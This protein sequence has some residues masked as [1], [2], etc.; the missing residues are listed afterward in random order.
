MPDGFQFAIIDYSGKVRYHSQ[1]LRNLNENLKKEFAD[2]SDLVSC[3]QA[4]SETSFMAEYYGK[5]YDVTIKPFP[6]LPYFVVIFKNLEYTDA[7]SFEPYVFT[8][9]MSVFFIFTVLLQFAIVFLV[10]SKRSF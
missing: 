4:G 1:P 10:S 8:L 7:R 9:S 2:S 6:N 3:L 5:E